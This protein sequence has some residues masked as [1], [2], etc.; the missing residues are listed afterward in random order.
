MSKR[1][2]SVEA[3]H[4]ITGITDDHILGLQLQL[5]EDGFEERDVMKCFRRNNRLLSA[6]ISR[7]EITRLSN[8]KDK[9][10]TVKEVEDLGAR[11]KEAMP[12][13]A[14]EAVPVS[15]LPS[16]VMQ[17]APQNSELRVL[18]VAGSEEAVAERMLAKQAV[19]GFFGLQDLSE[20]GWSDDGFATHGHFMLS[21]TESG[22]AILEHAKNLINAGGI[23]PPEVQRE[24]V[25]ITVT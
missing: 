15:T 24:P 17:P 11:I 4:E 3:Y 16:E 12:A 1:L 8:M 14:H 22:L 2:P 13:T 5:I 6:V 9:E 10:P 18:M 25:T 21:R 19:R 23:L 20:R 7:H